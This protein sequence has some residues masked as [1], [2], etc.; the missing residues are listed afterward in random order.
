MIRRYLARR[1][2]RW[3]VRF[4]RRN[5]KT[6]A[7]WWVEKWGFVDLLHNIRRP[8]FPHRVL[9]TPRYGERASRRT[10][11]EIAMALDIWRN[12]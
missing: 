11:R 10:W 2:M 9:R 3:A 8:N 5:P 12:P 7:D 6:V 4:V 1:K